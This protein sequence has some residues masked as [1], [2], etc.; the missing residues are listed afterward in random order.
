[1]PQR[2]GLFAFALEFAGLSVALLSFFRFG[3]HMVSSIESVLDNYKKNSESHKRRMQQFENRLD[4]TLR[5]GV[6]QD[7][8]ERYLERIHKKE[9]DATCARLQ[10]IIHDANQALLTQVEK[11]I[12]DANHDLFREQQAAAERCLAADRRLQR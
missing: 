3:I 10:Q 6:S 5:N 7:M 1:M 11:N 12:R 8:L 4:Q 9:S 2:K